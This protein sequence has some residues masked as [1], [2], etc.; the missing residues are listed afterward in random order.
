MYLR[1]FVVSR[2]LQ[3]R[4]CAAFLI[5]IVLCG[6]IAS[7]QKDV[8][9]VIEETADSYRLPD[10]LDQARQI[11]Q[12][13]LQEEISGKSV[14]LQRSEK[15]LVISFQADIL[16]DSG[17]SKIRPEAYATLDK[18]SRV[19]IEN[20]GG[21]RIGI[22]GHTDNEPIKASGWKSNWELSAARAL[23]VLHYLEDEKGVAGWRLSATGFGQEQPVADNTSKEGRQLNRRV[24]I[25]IIPGISRVKEIAQPAEQ[26][27]KKSE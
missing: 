6:C 23:S 2:L 13:R 20:V 25:V 8:R 4:T 16:F 26:V 17:R 21:L 5:L 19:I 14:E 27:L 10:E 22:E 1:M 12:Q 7:A 3:A 9:P 24:E 11:L 15:G 18:V